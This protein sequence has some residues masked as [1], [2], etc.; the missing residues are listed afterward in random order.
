MNPGACF[1]G[2]LPY[3]PPPTDPHREGAELNG[4]RG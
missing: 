3:A 2:I 1:P 4:S